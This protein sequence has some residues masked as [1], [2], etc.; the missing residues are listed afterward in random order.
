MLRNLFIEST[1]FPEGFPEKLFL[2]DLKSK[3]IFD[4]LKDRY[5]DLYL[6]SHSCGGEL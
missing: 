4:K 3:E 5:A 2:F 1:F 6:K